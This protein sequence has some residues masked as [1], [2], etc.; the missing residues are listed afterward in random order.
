M[1]H[2]GLIYT[3]VYTIIKRFQEAYTD[4]KKVSPTPGRKANLLSQLYDIDQLKNKDVVTLFLDF[5]D[6][7]FHK[8]YEGYK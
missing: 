6:I 4:K 2:N 3:L 7:G 1:R 8:G 5:E